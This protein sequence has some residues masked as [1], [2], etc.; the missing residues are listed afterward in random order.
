M[1]GEGGRL[2]EAGSGSGSD[3]PGAAPGPRRAA[4]SRLIVRGTAAAGGAAPAGGAGAAAGVGGGGSHAGG[5]ARTFPGVGRGLGAALHLPRV[6]GSGGGRWGAFPRAGRGMHRDGGGGDGE[7]AVTSGVCA[8]EVES[9][10]E[11]WEVSRAGSR[12]PS[13]PPPPHPGLAS[14]ASASGLRGDRAVAPGARWDRPGEGGLRKVEGTV[15]LLSPP[16]PPVS[17]G[18]GTLAPT[19]RGSAAAKLWLFKIKAALI[20]A[21]S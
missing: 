20:K 18:G 11:G 6:G 5:S 15:L 14:T 10:R 16:P 1:P 12:L 13:P 4:L 8:G 21:I 17:R 3:I 7:G 9:G 2:P 19:R